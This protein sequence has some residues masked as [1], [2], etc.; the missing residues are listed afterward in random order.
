M[1]LS[2]L[3]FSVSGLPLTLTGRVHVKDTQLL[4]NEVMDGDDEPDKFRYEISVE[5][6]NI[7]EYYEFD[8]EK[9]C[10]EVEKIWLADVE[11]NW[12]TVLM[13]R[14]AGDVTAKPLWETTQKD[15]SEAIA[16][17]PTME[18]SEE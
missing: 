15:S 4:G 1:L 10:S 9:P 6:T 18:D 14:L 12:G 3:G 16:L 8:S 13:E 5:G 7:T 17:P 11:D 2:R